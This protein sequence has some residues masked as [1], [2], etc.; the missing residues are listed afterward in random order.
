MQGED[1]DYTRFSLIIIIRIPQDLISRFYIPAQF[2]RTTKTSLKNIRK[3]HCSRCNNISSYGF[4]WLFI[5][6]FCI[7]LVRTM[8]KYVKVVDDDIGNRKIEFKAKSEIMNRNRNY[9]KVDKKIFI[10][11][12]C[13]EIVAFCDFLYKI[14]FVQFDFW[15]FAF[16][17]I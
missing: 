16:A 6:T 7:S 12:K 9:K 14:W 4:L 8:K 5:I 17:D 10:I 2:S 15:K 1:K 3:R 13:K 11:L